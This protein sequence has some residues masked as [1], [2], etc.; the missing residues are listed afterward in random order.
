MTSER[1]ARGSLLHLDASA[2]AADVSVSRRLT[3]LFAAGWRER[4][5]DA[6]YRYRDLAADPVP[7]LT[8][9]YARLGYRAERSGAVPV[10]RV[11]SLARDA[12]EQAEWRLTLPLLREVLAT[13]TLL[14]G[15]PLYNLTVPATLKAWIDRVNFP[16]AFTD[17][18]TGG[19]ALR[20]TRV[21]LVTAHGG[22]YGPGAPKEGLDFLTPYLRGYFTDRG[23]AEEHLHVVTAELTRAWDIP[24]LAPLRPAAAASV[25][26]ARAAVTA[27]VDLLD[28]DA[29]DA[30]DASGGV[31]GRSEPY[32]A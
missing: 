18:R 14:L 5:P 25:A 26:A 22:G 31:S 30:A 29:A 15:V 10:E 28:A 24:G 20:R 16:R 7:H 2:A 21:V 19:S 9:A 6:H 11:A 1:A 3:A 32:P 8:A 12:D 17:P 4:N 23:V 27:L 13:D